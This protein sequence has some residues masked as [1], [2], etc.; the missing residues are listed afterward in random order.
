VG[1]SSPNYS[2]YACDCAGL[3]RQAPASHSQWLG[4]GPRKRSTKEW[5]GA[6]AN[7]QTLELDVVSSGGLSTHMSRARVHTCTSTDPSMRHSAR[8]RSSHICRYGE[9]RP[10]SSSGLSASYIAL[11]TGQSLQKPKVTP[12]A[13][14]SS[15]CGPGNSACAHAPHVL[16]R[17]TRMHGFP[18]C[19]RVKLWASTRDNVEHSFIQIHRTTTC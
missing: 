11:Q 15:K 7:N 9:I 16:I 6:I 1:C 5:L 19:R 14:P 12:H 2:C 8:R 3:Y 17:R 4:C 13:S 10:S 18:R